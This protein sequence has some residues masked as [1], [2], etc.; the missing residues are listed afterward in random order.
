MKIIKELI[1]AFADWTKLKIRI[2]AS[3]KRNLF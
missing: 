3:E 2:N 1:K